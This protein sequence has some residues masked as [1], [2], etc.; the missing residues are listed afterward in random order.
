MS[1]KTNKSIV[2]QIVRL[3]INAITDQEQINQL[4]KDYAS[5]SERP[6][7][8][9]RLM[10]AES[11]SFAL[12][13]NMINDYEKLLERLLQREGW[14]WSEKFSEEYLGTAIK[15]ILATF[16]KEGQT[17][18]AGRLF[19]QLSEEFDIYS[20]KYVVYVPL[21]GINLHTD[22]F[23][24][25]NI[26]FRKMTNAYVDDLF[27]K[28]KSITMLTLSPLEVKEAH[29]AWTKQRLEGLKGTICAEFYAVAEPQRARERAEEEV[30]HVLDLLRYAISVLTLRGLNIAVGLQGE[31]VNVIRTTPTLS[32]DEQS[33]ELPSSYKG[34]LQPFELS[35]EN[36]QKMVQ[37]GIFKVANV[38]KLPG[39]MTD[40]EK[41]LLRGIH[42]FA[43]SQAQFDKEN[44]FLNLMTCL[45][46]FLTSSG[47]ALI[48]PSLANQVAEG[49][50]RL[51]TT[52]LENRKALKKRIQSLYGIR[53]GVSHGGQKA[54][55]ETDLE[56]LRNIA[57]E[58]IFQMIERKDEF[59]THKALLKWLDERR[60]AG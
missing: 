34:P 39:K 57:K 2:D 52:E 50:A 53:S 45:E 13:D 28:M 54:I 44:E 31:V 38:L 35:P 48:S 47:A 32:L 37:I 19:D 33:Y 12:V 49:A 60:L 18:S 17:E 58:L 46:T 1:Q 56:D 26:V 6:F 3:A 24:M 30:R 7:R 55:L 11:I 29:N 51:L 23:S 59:P 36:I 42:W 10:S 15:R 27:E 40:F 14:G 22:S 8:L 21:A 41:T 5:L 4:M 16:I 9:F 20:Q 25:G 43:I